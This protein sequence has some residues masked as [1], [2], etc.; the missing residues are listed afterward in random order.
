MSNSPFLTPTGPGAT[1]SEAQAK[2]P[3]SAG[4][5]A[6][7]TGQTGL[8]GEH[9]AMGELLRR[10]WLA[11]MI[12]GNSPL[13]DILASKGARTIQIQVKTRTEGAKGDT[14]LA[15]AKFA[16]HIYYIIVDLNADGASY[17]IVPGFELERFY[18]RSPCGIRGRIPAARL[19]AFK[20]RW[21]L[22]DRHSPDTPC[23]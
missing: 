4:A 5:P 18:Y 2:R 22:L 8:S 19:S 9:F 21:A 23:T 10:G 1:D 3:V 11:A 20:G 13:I 14:S 16:P 12:N 17:A 6:I 15:Q 7:G